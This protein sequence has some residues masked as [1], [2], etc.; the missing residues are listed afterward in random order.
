[1]SNTVQLR[2]D[3][4]TKRGVTNIF[5]SLGMDMSTGVKVYFEQVLK[6]KGIPFLLLTKEGYKTEQGKKLLEI[7]K[8]TQAD[9]KNDIH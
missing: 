5:K 9:Y 3:A 8:R 4:K 6:T 7:I 2:V 1:M